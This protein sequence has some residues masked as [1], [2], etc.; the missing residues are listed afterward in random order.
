M[1]TGVSS[2][3]AGVGREPDGRVVFVPGAL[4][5]ETVVVEVVEE[6]KRHA[7]ARLV[8]IVEPSPDRIEPGCA[9]VEQG[10]GGCDLRHATPQAQRSTKERIVTDALTR[11]GRLGD[12]PPLTTIDLPADGRRTT[13]RCLVIAGRAGYRRRRS[14]D[15]LTVDACPVL[16]PALEELVVEGRY[17]GVREVTLRMGARTGERLVLADPGAAAVDVPAGVVVV[18]ADELGAGR[19]A[20]YHEEVGGR[21]WRISARSFFQ[22]RPDG[23]EALAATVASMVGTGEGHLVDLYGGV[24]L[25]AGTVEWRGPITLVER[26]SSAIADAR[27]NLADRSVKVLATPVERWKPSP[28]AAVIADPARSG[29]G[30]RG[31]EQL[32]QTG[33]DVAVLV[34]CDAGALGRDV[35]LM[36]AAGFSLESVVV[37]DLFPQ[38]SRVEVVSRFVRQ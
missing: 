8:E 36:I 24:G 5:D 29:L 26:S 31:V 32:D 10:C 12:P 15:G 28:A 21:R 17:D 4:L 18:G 30:R 20:W 38:T 14:A 16:H 34:S 2:E 1:V 37:V 11:I 27:I 13:A 7:L 25:L 23:A 9:A 19:R 33:C 22:A 35:G 3:G 6:K